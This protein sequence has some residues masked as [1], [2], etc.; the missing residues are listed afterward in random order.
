MKAYILAGGKG[1]RLWP[2]NEY[3][4][5][6]ALPIANRPLALRTV[7]AV[8]AAGADSVVI[9]GSHQMAELREIFFGDPRVTVLETRDTSGSAETLEAALAASPCEDDAIVLFG[10]CLYS[11]S[12][13][14]AL[15]R[16][17]RSTASGATAL[18]SPVR[19]TD[20]AGDWLSVRTDDNGA[21]RF[22]AG[23]TD[24]QT[25]QVMEA[26][27]FRANPASGMPVSAYLATAGVFAGTEI[28]G[29]P[30]RSERHVESALHH[31]VAREGSIPA[32]VAKGTFVDIDKPWHIMEAC[33]KT[34]WEE[35]AALTA[36]KLADG[37]SIDPSAQIKGFVQLGK[38]SRIGRNVIIN[39]SVIVGDN[40]VI[41]NGAII[42]GDAVIGN[43]VQIANYCYIEGGSTIGNRCKVLHAAEFD[44]VLFDGAY[45]Y[46]YMEIH[47]LLGKNVDIG[48]S[49]VCGTLR[50]D[51]K[52]SRHT[53]NGRK[54]TPRF[55]ANATYIGDHSRTGV[56][57]TFYPGVTIG[58]NVAV[59][60]GVVVTEDIPSNEVVLLKQEL[61]RKP[62]GPEK[63]GW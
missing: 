30:P 4:N 18:I 16:T 26:F 7:D 43:N 2:Y 28:G 31:Y 42:D 47:G 23:H 10:D 1:S 24:D 17:H 3:R 49:C 37:A 32:C 9:A 14:D 33:Y 62:W 36:N 52:A 57:C 35:T 58:C 25:Y 19:E 40:T 53:V 13:L 45:L 5:K 46:H 34:V 55:C 21:I 15:V 63:Y 27:A 50:F 39:G 54:E 6:A 38:N 22:F 51:N 12:D 61:I 11:A 8:C 48:A 56:N 59:G 41:D 29:M 44:G 60:P 20:D